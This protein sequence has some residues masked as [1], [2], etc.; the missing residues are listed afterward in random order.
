MTLSSKLKNSNRE[1]EQVCSSKAE[2]GKKQKNIVALR[3]NPAPYG[4]LR[5]KYRDR[6]RGKG[7]RGIPSSCYRAKGGS[8]Q[9]KWPREE[10]AKNKNGDEKI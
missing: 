9:K 3:S 10:R 8:G 1:I 5:A 7:F 6:E 2:K 4:S